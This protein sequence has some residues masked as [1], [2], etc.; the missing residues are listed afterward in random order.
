MAFKGKSIGKEYRQ[1]IRPML[2]RGDIDWAI[3]LM[4]NADPSKVKNHE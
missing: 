1:A 4:A 3:A 2:W